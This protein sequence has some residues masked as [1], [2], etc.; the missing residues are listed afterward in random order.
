VISVFS[1]LRLTLLAICCFAL[2]ILC[3]VQAAPR[4]FA[5]TMPVEDRPERSGAAGRRPADANVADDAGSLEPMSANRY[6]A[7]DDQLDPI[8]GKFFVASVAV[9]IT[10]LPRSGKR[11]KLMGKYG[12][13]GKTTPGWAIGIR[14][15]STSTRPEVYWQDESGNGGWFTFERFRF[16]RNRWYAL[17]LVA[18]PG[19]FMSL[20]V[21]ELR[22]IEPV[23]EADAEDQSGDAAA[24]PVFLGGYS[25][26]D[27]SLMPTDAVLE[28][29]PR[30]VEAG[31]FRGAVRTVL[32][33]NPVR[34][35]KSPDKLS[36][37]I[38]GGPDE[39]AARVHE[40]ELRLW[41]RD[42]G[43]DHSPKSRS[44]ESER[45]RLSAP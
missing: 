3:A 8:P 17:T 11:Q 21:Q 24:A 40:Q 28:F 32:V 18:L 7:S 27:V 45:E 16:R 38:V 25:L 22:G 39:F 26:S 37:I 2:P 4:Y 6:V 33:A 31:D 30:R 20:Y 1:G 41:V 12:S 19:D 5:Y 43:A 15:L 23:A 34:L 35:P 42:D 44:I 14:R 10:S 9:N 13:V 29:A 36:E